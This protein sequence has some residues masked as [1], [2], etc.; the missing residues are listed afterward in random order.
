MIIDV[1]A[2]AIKDI[3]RDLS[4]PH[5]TWQYTGKYLRVIRVRNAMAALQRELETST[6]TRQSEE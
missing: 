2:D 3:N 5:L 1:L 6:D 4:N